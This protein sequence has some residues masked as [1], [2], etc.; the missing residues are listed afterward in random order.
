MNSKHIINN[1]MLDRAIIFATKAHAGITR[2]GD[3]RPYIMHPLAVAQRVFEYVPTKTL[4][5]AVVAVLHDVVEDVYQDNIEEGLRIVREEFG[6]DIANMVAELT[7]EKAKY[8]SIGKKEYL[9]QELNTMTDDALDVKL[10]DRWENVY[11]MKSMDSEFKLYYCEQTRYILSK[12]TRELTQTHMRLIRKIEKE[13]F[14]YDNNTSSC[15]EPLSM[16]RLLW[17]EINN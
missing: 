10:C 16:D 7:L 5:K 11:D 6:D 17:V 1:E 2:K 14:N 3:G 8:K 13:C 4:L 9:L 15:L 12:L